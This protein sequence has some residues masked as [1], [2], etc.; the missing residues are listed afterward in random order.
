MKWD[1]KKIFWQAMT[2]ITPMFQVCRALIPG[3]IPLDRK[4]IISMTEML[5]KVLGSL[6]T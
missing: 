4:P 2:I 3:N 5:G 6:L 1:Q